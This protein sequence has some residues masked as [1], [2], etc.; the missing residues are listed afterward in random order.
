VP[1]A[2]V[3]DDLSWSTVGRDG[4]HTRHSSLAQ[5]T[6]SNV[7]HLRVAWRF[8]TG[9]S[10]LRPPEI[11]QKAKFGMTPILAAGR[12]VLCT[13][14]NRV[15]ALD[16]QTG[17]TVWTFDAGLSSATIPRE[18]FNCRGLAQWHNPTVATGDADRL[19][20]ATNDR[21]VIALAARTGLPIRDFGLGGWV[22][23]PHTE[24]A[25]EAELQISS[26][27]AVVGDVLIVGSSSGDNRRV[28]APAGTVHALDARTG[29]IRW[30]FDPVP[31]N[32]DA[33]A[34]P[35]WEGEGAA[36]RAGQ[37]NVW[38]SITVDAE[39]DLAF[40]PTSSASPDSYG[41][42]RLGDN[43]YADSLVAIRASTG[44]IV[45]H[46]Q[47]VHHDL[48]DYDIPAGPTLFT[49]K[50][51]T[52]AT[53][54][55]VFATKTGFVFVLNR[56]TGAPLFPVEERSVAQSDVP[57]ERT[58]PTQPFSTGQPRLVPQSIAP[59]DAFGLTPFDRAACRRMIAGSRND[60]IFTPPS[61]Q[62]SLLIPS[63]AGGA[64]WG[65]VALDPRTNTVFVNTTRLLMK[66]TLI[67]AETIAKDKRTSE[68]LTGSSAARA[69]PQLGAPYGVTRELLLS[70]FGLPCNPPPWGTLAAIDLERG[71]KNWEVTLGTS[72]GMAPFG[73][74]F[75]WGTPNVGGPIVT[76]GGLVFIAAAM[77]DLL[78]AFDLKSGRELWAGE[79]PGG[80]Q[81]T[82]MTYAVGGRQYVVVAAG[83]HPVLG[84]TL[85]DALIAFAL[86]ESLGRDDAGPEVRQ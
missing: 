50:T 49:L 19:F 37:A 43:L 25:D 41:G 33:V 38:G 61:L 29:R 66:V 31:R 27:P 57:G 82:P 54:A 21:R 45:W 39:R 51:G 63:A 59:G 53:P 58:S 28:Q 47:T 12:L 16:P 77:D 9:E 30:T 26:A 74:A 3:P 52:T 68:K 73:L 83:G 55:L 65:G 56:E 40:L 85:S 67:P 5:I 76:D 48:W 78:R 46:F 70:P 10:A 62:G 79:L 44:E 15:F 14:F 84:T 32:Y 35:T 72:K 6:A 22:R 80:G 71:V 23:L 75:Q 11:A 81:A 69:Y 60:G 24:L 4:S 20:M 2:A 34:S 64:N 17:R 36:E 7:A 86:P 1:A 42:L 8:H 18:G 13:P